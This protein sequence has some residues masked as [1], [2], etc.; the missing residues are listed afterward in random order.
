MDPL[1]LCKCFYWR[2]FSGCIMYMGSFQQ[3]A[4]LESIL[5]LIGFPLNL[6][7]ADNNNS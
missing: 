6:I 2:E 3:G 5:V 7:F 4:P 1:Q